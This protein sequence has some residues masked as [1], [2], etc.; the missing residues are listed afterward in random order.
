[1]LL[2]A[3]IAGLDDAGGALPRVAYSTGSKPGALALL[4]GRGFDD[5][6]CA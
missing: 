1:M 2:K 5:V 6:C 4:P 3:G